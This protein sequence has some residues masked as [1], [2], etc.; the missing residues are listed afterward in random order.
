MGSKT[1]FH[2]VDWELDKHSK[3]RK[4]NQ[5]HSGYDNCAKTSTNRRTRCIESEKDST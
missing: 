5:K 1:D 4:V 2:P 3:L